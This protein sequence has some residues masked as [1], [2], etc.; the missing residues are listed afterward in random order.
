MNALT[1]IPVKYDVP[2]LLPQLRI[3]KSGKDAADFADLVRVVEPVARPK[4]LF[5]ACRVES[6]TSE[7]VT[8]EGVTFAS[9]ALRLNL[10][11][12]ETVFPFVVTCGME[13]DGAVIPGDDMLKQFWLDELKAVA[14]EAAR[15]HLRSHLLERYRVNDVAAMSPGAGDRDLWPIEQQRELFA[16]LGDTRSSVGVSLTDSC[17]MIPNKSVSGIMYP[18]DAAFKAC[19]LCHRENCRG[20]IADFDENMYNAVYADESSPEAMSCDNR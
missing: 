18:S 4:A 8:I 7:T 9:R 15:R 12:V 16:L 14:M 2:E 1:R 13:L 20:R 17:L 5:R 3:E 19:R 6:R 10:D 11:K